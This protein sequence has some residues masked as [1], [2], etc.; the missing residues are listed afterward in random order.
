MS[1][2]HFTPD[3]Y[4]ELMHKEVPRY[5]ELQDETAKATEGQVETILELGTGTGETARRVLALHP[6]SPSRRHRRQ[7]RDARRR[8][9]P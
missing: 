4:L 2:F 5:A 1:Q 8:G 6:R 3:D 7:R 9:H